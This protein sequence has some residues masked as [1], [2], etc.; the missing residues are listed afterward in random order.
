MSSDRRAALFGRGVVLLTGVRLSAVVAGFLVSVVAARVLGPDA[1]GAGAV[2]LTAGT[3]GALLANGGLNISAIYFLGRRPE[4]RGAISHRALTLGLIAAAVAFAIVVLTAPWLA[5]SVFGGAEP[6]LGMAAG[7]VAASL[8]SFELTGSI[9]LG[10]QHQRP[11]LMAQ[12]VEAAGSFALPVLLFVAVGPTA[13]SYVLG[14]AGAYLLA[15]VLAVVAIQR[16]APG[17]PLSFDARFTREAIVLGLRGQVGN[18]LQFLNLRL[19]LL[20]VPLLLNLGAAG[21]YVIAVRVS[22]VLAQVANAAGTLLF[23]AVSRLGVNETGLT[24]RTMRVTLLV[25]GVAGTL[26]AIFTVPLLEIFFGPAYAT[27]ATAVR[28]TVLAMVPLCVLRL[29]AGDLKGRGRVGLVSVSSGAALVAT[30]IFDLTLIPALGIEGAA[31]ASLLAYTI[32]AAALLVAYRRVT[33]GSLLMFVP[34]VSDLIAVVA[35]SRRLVRQL[36]A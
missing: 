12:I 13:A 14:A 35:S 20:L 5:P 7:L 18:V 4:E 15:A 16:A 32:G 1:L 29:L 3:L 11:Y 28:I 8:I 30:V 24:E 9:L 25:I 19:D 33:G 21:L 36:H 22:E 17:F 10:L 23:P 31:L 34:T 27:A 26:V 2:G 6:G